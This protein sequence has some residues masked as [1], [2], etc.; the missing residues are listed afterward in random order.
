M[1]KIV[2]TQEVNGS[3]KKVILDYNLMENEIDAAVAMMKKMAEENPANSITNI[4]RETQRS[5][6]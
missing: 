1:Y 3:K 5:P 4:R 2:G 6:I